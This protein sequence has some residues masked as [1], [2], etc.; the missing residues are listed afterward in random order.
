MSNPIEDVPIVIRRKPGASY[1]ITE[2]LIE[3]DMTEQIDEV[4]N[5]PTDWVGLSILMIVI[6]AM[7][8]LSEVVA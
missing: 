1:R 5:E 6:A 3:T 8:I 4:E 7:V 2:Q